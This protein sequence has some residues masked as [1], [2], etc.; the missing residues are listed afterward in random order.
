[1]L[2]PRRNTNSVKAW[3]VVRPSAHNHLGLCEG[4]VPNVLRTTLRTASAH[5]H[6]HNHATLGAQYA[7]KQRAQPCAQRLRTTFPAQPLWLCAQG[8]F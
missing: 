7:H 1:M 4:V 6:A 8:F 3:K 2:V 5:N